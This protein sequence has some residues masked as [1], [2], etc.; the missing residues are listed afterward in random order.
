M[1]SIRIQIPSNP[2]TTPA[3]FSDHPPKTDFSFTPKVMP[4]NVM[5][6]ACAPIRKMVS[7]TG[8]PRNPI[9]NPTASFSEIA[10]E[11]ERAE[12]RNL[13]LDNLFMRIYEDSITG[14]ISK[15]RYHKM[16]SVYECEQSELKEKVYSLRAE[17]AAYRDTT[18]NHEHWLRLIQ[19]Y[20]DIEEL[21]KAILH[22][23]VERIEI[24]QGTIE[25]NGCRAERKK[26][27]EITIYYRFVGNI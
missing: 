2:S 8:T 25:Y 9:E 24:G 7:K 21:D 12:K 4:I 18:E 16:S 15:E 27:Q 17:M 14:A 13:E 3:S 5:I 22:E 6:K 1:P 11:L 26:H 23:L 19:K 10:E 20:A